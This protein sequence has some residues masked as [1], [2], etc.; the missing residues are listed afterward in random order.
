MA[1][2]YSKIKKYDTSNGLGIRASIFFT[3]C[4]FHCKGCFNKEI[5]DFSAGKPFNEEAKGILLDYLSNE[6]VC[7]LSVLGGEPL[8][9][10]LSELKS[11][12]TEIK[13]LYPHK[14]IWMW[15]GYYIDELNEEQ[16]KVVSLVDRLV[17][18]RFVQDKKTGKTNY[19]GSENQTIWEVINNEDG[20]I[21]FVADPRFINN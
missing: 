16:K 15:T 9:Q 11:L 2:N 10:D 19:R 3:G 6:H 21:S 18:G 17:D 14:D 1:M 13:E 7:G 8:Q 12:L 20:T 5:W 4:N